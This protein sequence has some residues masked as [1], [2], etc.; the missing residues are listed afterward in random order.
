MTP[1]ATVTRDA[2]GYWVV[3]TFGHETFRH[4]PYRWRF[5]ARLLCAVLA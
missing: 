1:W 3:E 5:A 2:A 4:G